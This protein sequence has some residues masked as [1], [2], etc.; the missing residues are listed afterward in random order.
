LQMNAERECCN[1]TRHQISSRI[2]GFSP[3]AIGYVSVR[4]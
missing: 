3:V 4:Q 1:Y 2:P